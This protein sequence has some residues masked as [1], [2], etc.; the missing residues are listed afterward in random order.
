MTFYQC[1]NLSTNSD[2]LFWRNSICEVDE[3]TIGA[4]KSEI[5]TSLT[6][7]ITSYKSAIAGRY[8]GQVLVSKYGNV[9]ETV[10]IW[11]D[12]VDCTGSETSV[13]QCGH[14][15][16]G[17]HNNTHD[18]DVSI[19]CYFNRVSQYAGLNITVVDNGR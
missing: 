1:G 19:S 18:D 15:G 12:N 11:L 8:N 14:S 2:E 9:N 16:W 4:N 7:V 10:P 13:R 17:V 5:V 3:Y 6:D